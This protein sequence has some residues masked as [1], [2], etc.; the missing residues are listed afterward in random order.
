M[1]AELHNNCSTIIRLEQKHICRHA[2]EKH[3]F[4]HPGQQRDTPQASTPC[5]KKRSTFGLL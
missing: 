1:V 2:G 5:L 4:C 3:W